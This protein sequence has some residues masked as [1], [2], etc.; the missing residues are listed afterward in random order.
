MDEQEIRKSAALED[1]HWWYA[2]RRAVIRERLAGVAPGRALDVGCGSGGNA[3]T[4]AG[5]GWSVSALDHSPAAAEL[6]AARGLAVVR[7]DATRLPFPDATFDLV[8]STDAWEHIDDDE[9]V[10]REA[11]RVCRPGGRLLVAVPAGMDLWSGHDVALGHVR[12]YER[13]QLLDLV[14]RAGF[15]VDDTMG[16]NVL[17]RPVA[18]ARRRRSSESES[19]ME[20][21]HPVLNAA[22]RLVVRVESWLPVGR[23]RGISL[24]VRAHRPT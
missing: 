6:A 12:R 11:F 13:V 1:R 15:V 17:L 2:G 8:M 24:V 5:L 10:A 3:A 22:L 20:E 7:G 16:W 4:L 19:E 21:V 23:L 9:S 14:R 18:R